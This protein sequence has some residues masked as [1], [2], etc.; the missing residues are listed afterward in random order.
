[1]IPDIKICGLTRE[2]DIR[3]VN[4]CLPGYIGFMF[5]KP[6]R[7]YIEPEAAAEL[8]KILSPEIK[9]VGVFL[10]QPADEVIAIAQSGVIDMIQLHGSEDDSYMEEVRS[11]AHLPVIK[12]FSVAKGADAD[13]INRSAADLVLI[14][15]GRGGT[16]ETFD[17]EFLKGI[18]RDFFL[19]GGLS[20][21]NA[22]EASATGAYALDVSSG[23]E[24][25]GKK[26]ADKIRRFIRSVRGM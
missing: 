14:D 9:A 16:G 20:L 22:A 11:K 10:D 12:A 25:D 4:E 18:K 7:R 8:K 2:E 5:W 23:M 6:S 21:E 17:W 15:S 3:C 24:T 26:D 19:A 1:M 13:T